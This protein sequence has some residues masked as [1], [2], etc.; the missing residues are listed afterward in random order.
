MN[1]NFFMF[2]YG[3]SLGLDLVS[4]I[5][6]FLS[7]WI[8]SLMILSSFLIYN[9]KFYENYYLFL[10]MILLIFLFFSFSSMNLLMFYFWFESSLFPLVLMVFGWGIQPERIQAG[11]Y[12]LFYTLFSSLPLLMI[13]FVVE[14]SEYFLSLNFLFLNKEMNDMSFMMFFFF[15]FAF[16]VK[17]P[18]FILHVWLPKA[19]VEAPVA[20][21]MILAGIMLKLGG[22]GLIR[23]SFLILNYMLKYNYFFIIFSLLGGVLV[24]LMCLRQVDLKS[25]IAYSSVVHMS[26]VISGIMVMFTL[27]WGFSLCLMLAHGLCSSGLF[28]LANICY[29]RLNTRSLIMTKGLMMFMPSLTLWWFLFCV[30]NMAA[31]PTLNLMGEIGL[32]MSMLGWSKILL[33]LLIILS[34]FSACYSLY[35]FSFS[36]HG[37]YYFGS[38][39]FFSGN[40]REYLILFLHWFP[41]NFLFLKSELMI[42]L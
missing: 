9:M 23:I 38:F 34:F 19:H 17:L 5:F 11:L 8:S 42:F 32:L 13:M 15:I 14:D 18:I 30:G 40:V 27:S 2:S 37:K 26:F 24:S 10:I 1:L 16:L 39:S 12:L 35:L 25:L 29:E 20:G 21:S 4:Y 36:Q 3:F 7:V 6:I 22:Y 41:L 31:P 28:F 33:Y